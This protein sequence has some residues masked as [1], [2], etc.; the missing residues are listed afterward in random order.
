MLAYYIDATF[1]YTHL[2]LLGLFNVETVNS[3]LA[4]DFERD[5]FVRKFEGNFYLTILSVLFLGR[6]YN[7]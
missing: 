7:F 1:S 2:C 6:D 5:K 4:V 3:W